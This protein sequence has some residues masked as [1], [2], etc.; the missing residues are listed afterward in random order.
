LQLSVL[1][2]VLE[3]AVSDTGLERLGAAHHAVLTGSE[4][5]ESGV[6]R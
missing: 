3:R 6:G 2:S 4:S 5:G 1:Q